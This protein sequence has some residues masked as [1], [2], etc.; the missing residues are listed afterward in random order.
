MKLT[1]SKIK[2]ICSALAFVCSDDVVLNFT[3][4][5]EQKAKNLLFEILKEENINKIE[6]VELPFANVNY[7]KKYACDAR[8]AK[9][10]SDFIEIGKS[11][12][13]VDDKD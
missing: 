9:K 6:N 12:V 8:L 3:E 4:K 10:L 11:G 1:K 13:G 5:E 2:L 7:I